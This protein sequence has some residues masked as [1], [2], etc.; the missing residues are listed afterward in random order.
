MLVTS[1]GS[2]DIIGLL[3]GLAWPVVAVIAIY[4]AYRALQCW[5]TSQKSSPSPTSTNPPSNSSHASPPEQGAGHKTP[6]D[7]R[8]ML[9][10]ATFCGVNAAVLA[11]SAGGQ[12]DP[13]SSYRFLVPILFA[14]SLILSGFKFY[15]W[16]HYDKNIPRLERWIGGIALLFFLIGFIALWVR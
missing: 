1:F 14:V 15:Q 3:L 11:I 9:W 5:V 10:W 8:R 7:M 12:R 2:F 16:T 4:R 13:S 6:V